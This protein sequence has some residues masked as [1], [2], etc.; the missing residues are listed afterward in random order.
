MKIL[1][2]TVLFLNI[3][4]AIFTSL[5]VG[6]SLAV[7]VNPLMAA[8]LDQGIAIFVSVK[9]LI[10][11]LSISVLWKYRKR[12]IA[13]VGAWICVFIYTILISYVICASLFQLLMGMKY[14]VYLSIFIL[15]LIAWLSGCTDRPNGNGNADGYHYP[16]ITEDVLDATDSVVEDTQTEPDTY[17]QDCIECKYYFCPP[18]DAI[19]QKQICFDICDDPPT[20]VHESECVEYLECD[21]AQVI[22]EVD[23]PCVTKDGWVGTQDKTCQKGKIYYTDCESECEEEV[24]DGED[25]DCD[26]E[27]DEGFADI[28]ELCNNIDDNCNGIVD[29]GEWECDEGCGPG[30]NLCVAGEFICMA[31]LPEEEICD[32]LDNDCDGEIDE[33]QLNACM[34]CGPVPEETCN[35]IDDNC[36]GD[37]DEDLLQ[38]CSTDCGEG[39]EICSQGNWVSCN[40]PPVMIEICDGLDNDCDGQIDEDLDCTCTIQDVGV[41][42]PCQEAPLLCGQGFKTCECVDPECVTI[43]MTNCYAACYWMSSPWGSD[44]TCDPQIGMIL[45]QESCNNFDDNCNQQIDEDLYAAC[46][47]GPEGTIGVGICAPGEMMCD[48]GQWG[49]ENPISGLFT[50]GFCKDEVTPQPELCNGVDDDCDGETD[51]GEELSDTDILFIVDWSGSMSDE[52]SAVLIALNQFAGTYSDEQ[53]LQWATILGPRDINWDETLDLFHNM[54]GFTDFLAAMSSLNTWSMGGGSEMLLDAIYLSLRNIS[55]AL[56]KPIADLEWSH[57]S[58]GESTP[59]HDDFIINWRSGADRIIIVF[60]DEHPQSYMS[61]GNGYLTSS[62]IMLAAQGTPQLKLYVFSTNLIWEWDEIAT[63]GNG[64]YFPLTNNPTQMYNS[65]MEILDEIC[66][67][68]AAS[69]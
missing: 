12:K 13:Q 68:T 34:Q 43:T 18:L 57:W 48:E 53:V 19:W 22:M 50:P 32:G 40:A 62:D 15:L 42:F 69:P 10:I 52:M 67:S 29:E 24:C 33:E 54:S 25:N 37:T 23:I 9:L 41:L 60:T 38:P 27:I 44:P 21:P 63:M 66:G 8:L 55:G 14:L 65:L 1:L 47:T 49:N 31:P 35:G 17:Y 5:V 4:D 7:E 36:D 39:Y 56:T 64:K 61:D 16:P 11:V 20:L 3:L 51:W 6:N 45:A 46:Y 26:G 30:P 2:L 28:E 59:H 58:V